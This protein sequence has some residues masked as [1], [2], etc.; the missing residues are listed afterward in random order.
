MP[1]RLC[2]TSLPDIMMHLLY[3][4]QAARLVALRVVRGL[5]MIRGGV[6]GREDRTRFGR[7]R[8]AGFV[9]ILAVR[10]LL[11]GRLPTGRLLAG[12]MLAALLRG[13]HFEGGTSSR[14]ASSWRDGSAAA[15]ERP[16]A[17]RS[18]ALV[19]LP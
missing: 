17:L 3:S 9:S 14:R 8:R 12:R 1:P 2:L 11:A 18:A 4:R 10:F 16:S 19:D 13:A 7:T 15:A 6:A 5:R